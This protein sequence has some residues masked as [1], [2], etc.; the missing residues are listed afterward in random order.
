MISEMT[1]V[2]MPVQPITAGELA[3]LEPPTDAER[4]KRAMFMAAQSGLHAIQLI[5][6]CLH[7]C[8]TLDFNGSGAM[9]AR[10]ELANKEHYT[11]MKELAT[12][13]IWLALAE[14]Y[15]GGM[16]EWLKVFFCD[17]WACADILF[18]FPTSKEVLDAYP[19]TRDVSETYQT[20]AF[21]MCHNLHLG[22]TVQDA[23]LFFIETLERAADKRSE[24]LNLALKRP[25]LE[26]HK[27]MDS[28]VPA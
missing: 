6:E 21:R 27:I 19:A 15:Q 28:S 16:P 7:H 20:A 2:S 4:H 1:E 8:D 23:P 22:E 13:S 11:A 10:M 14:Q 24:I 12:L 25:L 18:D 17:T 9:K 26:L 5:R 3:V